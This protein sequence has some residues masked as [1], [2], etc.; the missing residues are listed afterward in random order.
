[1]NLC[2]CGC[3]ETVKKNRVFV[4]NE[5]Q[6]TWMNA[7]G[8]RELNALMPDEARILGGQVAGRQAAQSGRLLEAAA[9]GGKR[10]REI[11]EAMRRDYQERDR[12]RVS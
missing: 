7:G 1:M 2:K 3:G 5:H 8:A 12:K 9:L 4:N 10:S 11:A 6:L